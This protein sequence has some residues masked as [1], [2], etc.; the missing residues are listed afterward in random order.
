MSSRQDRDKNAKYQKE[1]LDAMMKQSANKKCADCKARGPRWVSTNLGCF[2][3][4]RC[5]GIHRNLG[6]H[7]SKVRSTTLDRWTIEQVSRAPPQR[8]SSIV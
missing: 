7:I 8:A 2:I 5:S 6:T 1:V 4:I 3:C